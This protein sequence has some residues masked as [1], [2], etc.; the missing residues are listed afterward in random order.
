MKKPVF[1]VGQRIKTRALR[2]T[3]LTICRL[4]NGEPQ[5]TVKLDNGINAKGTRHQF[6]PVRR[7]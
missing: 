5:F 3:V 6:K 7:T 2:G 4:T 1:K